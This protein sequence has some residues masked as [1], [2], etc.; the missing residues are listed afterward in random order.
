ML[1]YISWVLL[2]RVGFYKSGMGCG[3][4]TFNKLLGDADKVNDHDLSTSELRD[5]QK[6]ELWFPNLDTC[7][8]ESPRELTKMSPGHFLRDYVLIDH[9][10]YRELILLKVPLD[11]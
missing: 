10:E 4:C 2:W 1:D 11:D 3:I 8:V 6:L 9:D 5:M 7:T